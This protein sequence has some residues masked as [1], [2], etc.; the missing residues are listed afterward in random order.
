MAGVRLWILSAWVCAALL[1]VLARSAAAQNQI[2][3]TSAVANWHDPLD[4]TPGVQGGD[5]FI[6][7]G[8]PT[9]SISWGTTSGTPQSGYDV[10]ITIPD[11]LAFPVATFSH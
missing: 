8:V 7:N 10:T 4:D 3:F 6:T 1:P 2:T 11:P 5:P 9:S